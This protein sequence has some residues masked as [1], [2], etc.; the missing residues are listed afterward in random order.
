MK[1][2]TIFLVDDHQLFLK[3]LSLLIESFQEY[4]V[5]LEAQNG[6]DLQQK[7]AQRPEAADLA[8]IDVNMP[9]MD[10]VQ[11]AT[12]LR[13]QYPGMH[14]IALSMNDADTAIISMFKAGCCA[15]LPKD[16]HPTE[17]EKALLSVRR[18]GYYHSEQRPIHLGKLLRDAE[19]PKGPQLTKREH[20]FLQLSC[21]ELTYKQ[22]AVQMGL[23]ERTVDG[24][25]EILFQKLQVQSRVGMC[26]E[27]LRL[28]L[29]SLS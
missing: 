15:Y 8:L 6:Q 18:T 26:L 12:W 3:S 10:G 24:Y 2:T 28:R 23:S 11:T 16:I 1:K 22:I 19:T 14:L 5:L 13:E 27:A 17:L 20:E 4:E 29:I 9:L 21:S 7:L 25:R